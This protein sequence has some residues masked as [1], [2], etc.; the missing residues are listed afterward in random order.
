[1]TSEVLGEMFEGEFA[2][3]CAANFH[4]CRWGAERRVA[5]AQTQLQG[6]LSAPAQLS[7][8]NDKSSYPFL[9]QNWKCR[10]MQ[11]LTRIYFDI[12]LCVAGNL[13]VNSLKNVQN[14]KSG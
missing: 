7:L 8:M 14:N 3:T 13:V 4:W 11:F 1:M 6:P 2:D 12:N 10:R 5:R 9:S